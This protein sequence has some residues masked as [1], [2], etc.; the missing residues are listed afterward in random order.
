M[1]WWRRRHEDESGLPVGPA[2]GWTQG[3]AV[4][5]RQLS[6]RQQLA[7]DASELG[8]LAIHEHGSRDA[9]IQLL[10]TGRLFEGEGEG[11]VRH[12]GLVAGKSGVIEGLNGLLPG[13]LDPV[14][15]GNPSR[16]PP[17]LVL[18]DLAANRN[19]QDEEDHHCGHADDRPP[20]PR[21]TR[22]GW[23]RSGR[24]RR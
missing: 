13:V 11:G 3:K 10:Q 4:H 17:E 8:H 23:T 21:L 15:L 22:A 5:R 9:V 6:R 19:G 14:V 2:D 1:R 24:F 18:G 16:Q 7:E 12:P 20:P